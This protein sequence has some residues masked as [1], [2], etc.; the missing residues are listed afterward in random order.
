MRASGFE[1]ELAAAPGGARQAYEATTYG[2]FYFGRQVSPILRAATFDLLLPFALLGLV[3]LDLR[4]R[5]ALVT[6][7]LVG[8]ATV[9]V[10]LLA[11]FACR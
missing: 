2:D 5:I 9:P 8:I 4:R 3:G 10:L 6:P 1:L 7:V 11:R